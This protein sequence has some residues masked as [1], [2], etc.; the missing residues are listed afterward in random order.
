MAITL[1]QKV[2]RWPAINPPFRNDNVALS[3]KKDKLGVSPLVRVSPTDFRAWPEGL[4][5]TPISGNTNWVGYYQST[6]RGQTWAPVAVTQPVFSP[7]AG[8]AAPEYGEVAFTSVIWSRTLGLW[9]GFYHGGNNS[10][11]R[12]IFL[13]TSPDGVTWTK[14]GGTNPTPLLS[15]SGTPGTADF[16]GVSDPGVYKVSETSW[17]M[18][19]RGWDAS[20]NAKI[21]GIGA[22][23]SSPFGPWT[24][25]GTLIDVGTAG[26]W[27]DEAVASPVLEYR[28]GRFHCLYAGGGAPGTI[29]KIGYAYADTFAGPWTKGTNNPI[30][31]ATTGFGGTNADYDFSQAG[32]VASWVWESDIIQLHAGAFNNSAGMPSV[33]GSTRFEGRVAA[34]MP[35]PVNGTPTRGGRNYR[36]YQ[37]SSLKQYSSFSNTI[38]PL[39]TNTHSILIC[40]KVPKAAVYRDLV[41]GELAFNRVFYIQ[42]N[43]TG[44]PEAMHRTT[45]ALVQITGA[46]RVDDNKRRWL[47]F[48]RTASNAF[49]FY[50]GDESGSTLIGSS[51]NA[52]ALDAGA[53]VNAFGNIH[54][55]ASPDGALDQPVNGTLTDSIIVIGGTI[56]PADALAMFNS[57]T[58][59]TPSGG[60]MYRW[61]MGGSATTTDTEAGGSGLNLTHVNGPVQV[62][63]TE[64]A[65][66]D[67]SI[68]STAAPSGVSTGG[69][70]DHLL[71]RIPSVRRRIVGQ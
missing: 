66:M 37:G 34:W 60:T 33:N 14:Y 35:R 18:M 40:F 26:A 62:E 13:A 70:R 46:A 19:A 43:N 42:I 30:W 31:S 28:D 36:N 49:D 65:D 32:D 44:F 71:R 20:V 41:L 54:P 12:Q 27:D 51:A 8:G 58:V 55:S 16:Y 2:T 3:W 61:P 23:A 59:P 50:S 11:P 7:E 17:V 45:S 38:L 22:T 21:R 10:N 64:E 1:D 63:W 67:L 29:D 56:S 53:T 6:D 48:R 68:L 9:C 69:V 57:R 39:N 47:L 15:A 4:I 25:I 24:K 5:G 52:P